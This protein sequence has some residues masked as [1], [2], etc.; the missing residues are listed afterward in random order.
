VFILPAFCVMI[1]NETAMPFCTRYC[2]IPLQFP[3]RR[4]NQNDLFCAHLT[5]F[6]TPFS[7]Q[8]QFK[9]IML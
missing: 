1:R 7:F 6:L 4:R 3:A 5:F 2:A 8:R 9:Y